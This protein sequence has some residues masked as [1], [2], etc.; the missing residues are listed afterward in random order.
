[1][2]KSVMVRLQLSASPRRLAASG[3]WMST[4]RGRVAYWDC[5]SGISGDMALASVVDAG[6]PLASIVSGL[7][8]LRELRGEWRLEQRDVLKGSG[9]IRACKIDVIVE[10]SGGGGGGGGGGCDGHGHSHNGH[11]HGHGHGGGGGG[12]GGAPQRGFDAIAAMIGGADLPPWVQEK[13]ISAFRLLGEAEAR[14]HGLPLSE[15]HFH[16]VGAVDSI[17]DTVGTVIGLHL[18]GVER[19]FASPLPFTSGHVKCDHGVMPVPAPAV[20]ELLKGVPMVPMPTVRGELITPTGASLL[21][22]LCEGYGLPPAFTPSAVGTGAGTKELGDIPNILRLTIGE[23]ADAQAAAAGT[24]QLVQLEAN[25][26]DM[27]P[28]WVDHVSGLM[29]AAGAV[30]VWS[31]PMVMKKQ[32]PAFVLS[33]LCSAQVADAVRAVFYTET[34]TLGVRST[35]CSRH[36][37]DR[38]WET[39][40]VMGGD[41]RVKVGSARD[42]V[43]MNA[44]PEFDDCVRVAGSSGGALKDVVHAAREE[45]RRGQP[46]V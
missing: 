39:V 35:P 12:G 27:P 20:L 2:L 5:A 34:T 6:A 18:L 7:E 17:V 26:D 28:Q 24:E 11:G 42:G 36:S 40:Q 4:G 38:H 23:G 29:F 14:M 13:S 45:W 1:M 3:R 19:V 25:L 22:A 43:V 31:T 32:R 46:V 15:V 41:V 44:H 8:A 9:I 33:A 16:E 10:G 21:R 30:D 37:L